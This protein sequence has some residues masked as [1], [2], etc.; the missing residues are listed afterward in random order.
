MKD[1]GVPPV[2]I[3]A[4]RGAFVLVPDP[5][6][7]FQTVLAYVGQR[8][9]ESQHFLKRS[10]MTLDLRQRPFRADE[11]QSLRQLLKEKGE[12]DLVAVWLGN[13]VNQLLH[14]ASQQLGTEL[15]LEATQEA[16]PVPVIVRTT[17]RS[18]MRIESEA[19]C[20]VLGDVNPGAEIVAT[21]DIIVFGR[22]RGIVHAGSRGDRAARIWA[23]SIEP[24]QIRIADLVA[25]SPREPAKKPGRFE[26]AEIQGEAIQVTTL[27]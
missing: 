14:W 27:Q 26:M 12:I 16:Q 24:S 6:V 2:Q 22:L 23:M 10:K 17:C 4:N 8:L 20:V 21:G 13:N 19:D 9:T 18:G 7:S 15:T 1:D 3:K 25:V 5:A 11:V